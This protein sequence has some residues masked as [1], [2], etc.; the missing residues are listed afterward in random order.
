[1]TPKPTI[2]FSYPH[3]LQMPNVLSHSL[4]PIVTDTQPHIHEHSFTKPPREHPFPV[5]GQ[6]QQPPRHIGP[7]P[8]LASGHSDYTRTIGKARLLVP[9]P[10]SLWPLPGAEAQLSADGLAF[11][12][13]SRQHP[14]KNH[15]SF[16]PRC[17][18]C[19]G[20][21]SLCSE[22]FLSGAQKLTN[23]GLRN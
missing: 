1:M 18:I 11:P 13:Y 16:N 21:A 12:S 6:E 2:R 15:L 23:L 4:S 5:L 22:A 20:K 14:L 7:H 9:E 10:P 17:P 19:M 8:D 3:S